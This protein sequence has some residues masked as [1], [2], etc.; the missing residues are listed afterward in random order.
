MR[1]LLVLI[2]VLV[3]V[4]ASMTSVAFGS[5]KVAYTWDAADLGQGAW[6]GG[7]L[8]ADGTV[9][10]DAAYSFG[11]S[12]FVGAL[13]PI[14]W[15]KVGVDPASGADLIVLFFDVQPRKGPNPFG[16]NPLPLGPLPATGVPTKVTF[17]GEEEPTIFRVTKL[18]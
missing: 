8:F 18:G 17:P 5:A 13:K 7:D 3:L 2:G 10:G 14:S 9:G 12:Q 11:N 16:I 15:V 6:G 4:T 1:K